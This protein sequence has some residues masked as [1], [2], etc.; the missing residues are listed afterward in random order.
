MFYRREE[1]KKIRKRTKNEREERL[2][3]IVKMRKRKNFRFFVLK[4]G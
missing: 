1:K 2:I 3:Q 4:K